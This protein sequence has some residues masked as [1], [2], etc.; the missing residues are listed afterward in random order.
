MRTVFH[1][2]SDDRDAQASALSSVSN[3]LADDSVELDE[4]AVV[5]SGGAVRML[6]QG[7]PHDSRVV[8]LVDEVSFAACSNSLRGMELS[9]EDLFDGVEAV[10]SG[11]GELTRLQ[12]EG[13]AYLRP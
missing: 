4:V 8:G 10:P 11:V 1:V 9:R 2:S 5:V 12:N 3:L 7:S 13:Y 6:A